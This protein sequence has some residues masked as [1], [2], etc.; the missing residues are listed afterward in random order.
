MLNTLPE[1]ARATSGS[2]RFKSPGWL[3]YRT[4][5]GLALPMTEH[6]VPPA[7]SQSAGGSQRI[8][9]RISGRC[10]PALAT[11]VRGALRLARDQVEQR[12]AWPMRLQ[13]PE[14]L[15]HGHGYRGLR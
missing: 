4:A 8:R 5:E 11:I 12:S 1:S 13:D 7:R 14:L 6:V 9:M 2:S 15:A 10:S 3:R